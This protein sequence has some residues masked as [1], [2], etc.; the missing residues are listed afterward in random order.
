ME[1]TAYE[2]SEKISSLLN[3]DDEKR[4]VIEYGLAAIFQMAAIVIIISFIGILCRVFYES[5]IIFL[6]V[7]ILKKSTGGAH[8][9]TMFGCMVISIFSILFL[10]LLSKYVFNL[11]I[12]IYINISIS[13]VIY[14]LCIAVF[15]RLVP[16]DCANKRI[17]KPEK[18]NR[19]R[20]QSFI[21]LTVY[22][23][24]TLILISYASVHVGLYSILFSIRFAML[25]QTLML[26][27]FAASLINDI[28]SKLFV[29]EG[30]T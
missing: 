24:L 18:I 19:L 7:G 10:A 23:I 1:K 26:T 16:V 20:R 15:Y 2:L 8:S 14:L 29:K 27:R 6:G 17:T 12:D 25:W 4:S 9:Q 30:K 3:Y 13:I 5:I 28:D 21:I 11:P 22:F